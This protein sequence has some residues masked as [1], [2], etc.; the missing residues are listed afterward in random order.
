MYINSGGIIGHAICTGGAVLGGRLISSKIS[1]KT[2][3]IFGGIL[4]LIFAIYGF[5]VGPED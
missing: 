3:N 2:V 4:F 1:P 5:A